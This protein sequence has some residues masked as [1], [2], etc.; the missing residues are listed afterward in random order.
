MSLARAVLGRELTLALRSGGGGGLGLGF[1][2]IVLLLAPLGIGPDP[3][4]LAAVAGGLIWIAALLACLL[5]LDRL[6]Q[7]DHEDGT[8]DV[9]ALS[10]LPLAGLVALKA[11]AHWL[12]TGLPLVIAAPLLAVTLNLPAPAYP[13]LVASLAIGTPGLSFLGAIGAA[14]TLGIRRGGLLLSVLVLP[15]YIPTLILGARATSAAA[16]SG[17]PWPA[18]LLLAGLTLAILALAPFTAAAALR[19]NLR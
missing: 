5:S 19:I 16:E 12:T 1:F 4:R 9:L 15:L 8:L 10:P 7:A 3:G 6:F 11:L 17:D 14:L 2:L 18:L 13:W